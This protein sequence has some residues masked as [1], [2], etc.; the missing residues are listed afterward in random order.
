MSLLY[1]LHESAQPIYS[2]QIQMDRESPWASRSVFHGTRPRISDTQE[3]GT[4]EPSLALDA[5][6][7]RSPK[8]P[9]RNGQFLM[10]SKEYFR[11]INISSHK[12]LNANRTVCVGPYAAWLHPLQLHLQLRHSHTH[13]PPL[14]KY[15]KKKVKCTRHIKA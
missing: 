14:K 8:N 12:Y 10:E 1:L 9:I 15:K 4:Q 11:A 2:G 6:G 13:F 7:T 5:Q 3:P